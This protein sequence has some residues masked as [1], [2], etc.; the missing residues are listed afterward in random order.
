[1]K[2]PPFILFICSGNTCRSVM[3]EHLLRKR[4]G[5]AGLSGRIESAG[6]WA[7]EGEPASANVRAVL[8]R[9]GVGGFRH[10]SRR[11]TSGQ[12][13]EADLIVVMTEAHRQHLLARFPHAEGKVRLLKEYD[14]RSG[15]GDL[16]DPLGGDFESYEAM[17]N[18]IEGAL[19]ELIIAVHELIRGREKEPS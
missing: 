17:R 8:D 15:G 2:R 1:M 4:L 9:V 13:D 14:S 12:V 18:E 11:V 5:E 3:A 6:L 7:V 19:P 16:V 10:R